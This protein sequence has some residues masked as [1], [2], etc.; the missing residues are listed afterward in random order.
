MRSAPVRDWDLR[1]PQPA[2]RSGERPSRCTRA[3]EVHL[4]MKYALSDEKRARA[5]VARL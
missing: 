3:S 4:L 5:G 1:G 2:W